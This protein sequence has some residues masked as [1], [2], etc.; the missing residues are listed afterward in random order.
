MLFASR[1]TVSKREAG[2]EALDAGRRARERFESVLDDFVVGG[3]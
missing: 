3:V 1:S 2:L